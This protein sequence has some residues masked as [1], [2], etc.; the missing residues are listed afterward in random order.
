MERGP[1][2][3]PTKPAKKPA[4]PAPKPRQVSAQ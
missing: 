4:K 2:P 1:E 3:A